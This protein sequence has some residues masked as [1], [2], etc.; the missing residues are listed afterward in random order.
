MLEVRIEEVIAATPM[1]IWEVLADHEGMHRWANVARSVRTR[2]GYSEPNGVG[3]IRQ[4]TARGHLMEERI[5]TFVPGERLGYDVLKGAP[6]WVA[7]GDIELLPVDDKTT[8]LTWRVTLHPYL[9]ITRWLVKTVLGRSLTG[10][11]KCL[12]ERVESVPMFAWDAQAKT[13]SPETDAPKM[14]GRTLV[15]VARPREDVLQAG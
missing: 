6:G 3:A 14:T 12:K 7:R 2:P 8:L 5:R 15:T 9:R 13:T 1:Q 11:V 4:L 10:A